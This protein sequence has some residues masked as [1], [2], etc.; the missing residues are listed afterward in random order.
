MKK[1]LKSRIIQAALIG[2]IAT[3]IGSIAIALFRQPNTQQTHYGHGD[4]IAI[5]SMLGS[6]INYKTPNRQF[7]DEAKKILDNFL[8]DEKDK[9]IILSFAYGNKEAYSLTLQIKEYLAS[10]GF[11]VEGP[12][13]KMFREPKEGVHAIPCIDNYRYNC[14]EVLELYIG[15][16]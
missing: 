3:A 15:V 4:N 6:I 10:R 1:F 14:D 7:D 9:L 12:H 5:E 11:E 13:A 2:L 16:K 8:E